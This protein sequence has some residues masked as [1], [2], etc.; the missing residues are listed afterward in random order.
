MISLLEQIEQFLPF[1]SKVVPISLAKNPASDKRIYLILVTSDSEAT[2]FN[3]VGRRVAI[4]SADDMNDFFEK[5]MRYRK[6]VDGG[7]IIKTEDG[8]EISGV[9]HFFD[10]ANEGL[11]R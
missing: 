3:R 11:R 4:M 9:G 5:N 8:T 6:N 2:A 10:S 7:T 1:N